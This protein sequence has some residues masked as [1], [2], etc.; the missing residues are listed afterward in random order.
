[1]ST[2]PIG[3]LVVPYDPGPLA[4]KVERRRRL[5]R[6]RLMSL[7]ITIV[8]MVVVYVW[9]REQLR[10]AGSV[11][12]FALVIGFSVGFVLFT[13]VGYLRARRELGTI[14]DGAAIRIGAPGIQVANLAAP[15]AQVASLTTVKGGLGREP[16][17]RLTLSDGQTATVPLDQVTV[18]P[19]TL[20][21]TVRAFSGGRHGIDLSALET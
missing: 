5:L 4:E 8:I 1:M 7:G 11:V 12:I 3:E 21:T 9:Q 17:L 14:G 13:L 6:S 18:F 19:A 20:D 16:L 2:G 10:G 15:W